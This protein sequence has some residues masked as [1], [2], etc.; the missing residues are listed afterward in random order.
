[1]LTAKRYELGTY[2]GKSN[3]YFDED[4]TYKGKF[5]VYYV[6]RRESC[7]LL[8]QSGKVFKCSPDRWMFKDEWEE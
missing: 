4:K 6:G 8:R 1:M 3:E 5:D 7:I 2:I